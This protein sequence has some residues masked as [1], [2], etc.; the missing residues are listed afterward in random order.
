[1]LSVSGNRAS[2]LFLSLQWLVHTANTHNTR[3]F[4]LVRV[5]G[6]NKLLVANNGGGKEGAKGASAPGGTVQGAAFG[7]AKM[8]F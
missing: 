2:C 1:M 4:C 6:V 5:G 8:E 7:G 3:Q